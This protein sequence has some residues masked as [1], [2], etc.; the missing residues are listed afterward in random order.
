MTHPATPQRRSRLGRAWRRLMGREDGN[1]TVEFAILFPGFMLLFMVVFELGLMMTRYMMFDRAL[2]ISVR[3]MRLSVNRN[4]D[5]N[6]VK[7]LLC[8]QTVILNNHCFED[9]RLEMVRL[10][11]SDTWDISDDVTCR[12]TSLSANL[13]P[14]TQ[15][16]TGQANDVIFVRACMAME[17]FFIDV[18]LGKFLLRNSSNGKLYMI[19]KSALSVEPVN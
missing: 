1:A 6:Q 11:D 18:G 3:E 16:D 13:Q 15:F 5:E 12:N 10:A 7:A 9:L 8:A 14:P 2:D 4:F 19:A 17:P